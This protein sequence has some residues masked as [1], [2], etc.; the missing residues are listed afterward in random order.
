MIDNYRTVRPIPRKETVPSFCFGGR[1]I[2]QEAWYS[3]RFLPKLRTRCSQKLRSIDTSHEGE[4][5]A[6]G[7]RK[8]RTVLLARDREDGRT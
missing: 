8:L 4:V 1:D 6:A 2:S 7:E 5:G 3:F